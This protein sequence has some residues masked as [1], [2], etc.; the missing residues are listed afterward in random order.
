MELC[1]WWCTYP[2]E[3]EVIK[4]PYKM[5]RSGKFHV[6]GNFCSW[7]CAKTYNLHEHKIRAGEIQMFMTA[8]R[9]RMYGKIT[10]LGCA[11]NKYTLKKFGGE[12]SI[13][14]FRS[15]FGANPPTVE[16]PDMHNFI[17]GM[18]EKKEYVPKDVL[19]D[20]QRLIAIKGSAVKAET[21]RLKRPGPVKREA[22]NLESALGI[23]RKPKSC[24]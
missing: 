3:G 1:C 12:L 10:R 14:E 15:K 4:L 16:M 22:N 9:K 17:H 19:S 2:I 24:V 11:P 18:V 20:A 6:M 21:L 7:E 23:I 13:E 8:M 5:E